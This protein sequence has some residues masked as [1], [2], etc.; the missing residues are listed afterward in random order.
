M[1]SVLKH[2]AHS[3][4]V[5]VSHDDVEVVVLTRLLADQRVHTPAPVQPDSNV[6]V[7][8]PAENLH[9]IA[10]IHRHDSQATTLQ[11]LKRAVS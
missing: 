10:S 6:A 4:Y 8:E 11:T 1:E 3:G 7:I 9:H 2:T 5:V